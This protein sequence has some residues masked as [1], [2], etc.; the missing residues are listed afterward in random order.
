MVTNVFFGCDVTRLNKKQC[1]ELKNTCELPLTR[2]M[3]L[4]DKFT[5]KL[6]HVRKSAL[7]IGLVEPNTVMDSL[8][9]KLNAGNKRCK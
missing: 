6:L 5:R 9:L 2:K 8:D 1:D 7:G 3:K 4:G